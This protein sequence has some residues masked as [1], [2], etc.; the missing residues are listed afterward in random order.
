MSV[1]KYIESHRPRELRRRVVL[2]ARLRSGVQWSDTCILNI[3]SRGLMIHS[4]RAAPK[5]SV[6]EI[7]RGEHVIVARVVWRDGARVGLKSDDRLPVEN[8]MSLTQCRSL[9]LV[10]DGGEC[11]ERRKRVRSASGDSRV[12]ARACEFAGVGMIV[13][14]LALGV[15]AM[16]QEAFA[17]PLAQIE[18]ALGS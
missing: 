11:V 14:A 8:I 5:G 4:G 12:R 10:A 17:A 18:A 3:S 7:R 13:L 1:P 16:A 6:V 2:P 15:W 9:R